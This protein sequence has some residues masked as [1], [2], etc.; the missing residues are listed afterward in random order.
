MAYKTVWLLLIAPVSLLAITATRPAQ[1]Q[2]F[3]QHMDFGPLETGVLPDGTELPDLT[4]DTLDPD[5]PPPPKRSEG[6]P[7]PADFFDPP[8]AP[9]KKSRKSQR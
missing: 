6:L 4:G 3:G 8:S 5:A 2:V 1:A 7:P 9:A